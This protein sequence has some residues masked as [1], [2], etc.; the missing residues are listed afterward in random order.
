MIALDHR[1]EAAG[2]AYFWR[3][4]DLHSRGSIGLFELHYFIRD[5]V[6]GLLD[7]GDEPTELE[8]IIDEIIDLVKVSPPPRSLGADHRVARHARRRCVE[9]PPIP[10]VAGLPATTLIDHIPSAA[11][12]KE[13][14]DG[15]G[16]PRFT[17]AE[18]VA[19]GAGAVVV[20]MMI[21]VQGFW[22]WDNRESL[23][24]YDEDDRYAR[25]G[26]GAARA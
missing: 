9:L 20:S 26:R 13:V 5:V 16:G 18:L 4:L 14:V 11:A 22:A 3:V 17:L 15:G 10:G 8:N 21:D 12:S 2:L 24:E 6:Q 7:A 19:C 1:G 25:E 23:V